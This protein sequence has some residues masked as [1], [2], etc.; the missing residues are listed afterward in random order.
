MLKHIRYGLIILCLIFPLLAQ[1]K[2]CTNDCDVRFTV[3]P[4]FTSACPSTDLSQTGIY[5]IKND[6]AGP[7]E[8]TDNIITN[9]DDTSPTG[10]SVTIVP[11]PNNDC[12][13]SSGFT[14]AAGASCN[15]SVDFQ[16]PAPGMWIF[17]R[18]LQITIPA[19]STEI[20]SPAI[21]LSCIPTIL[22]SSTVT[23]TGN[24]FVNGDVAVSPGTAITG[25]SPGIVTN[26]SL[27]PTDSI[28]QLA[29]EYAITYY[30]NAIAQTCTTTYSTPQDLGGMTLM[31]GVYCFSSSAGLTGNLT[32]D[33]Q[34]NPNSTFIFKIGSTLIAEAG[35]K[36][37]LENSAVNSN[38]TW[39]VGS[40]ATLKTG[41]AFQGIIDAI[42]SITFVTRASLAGR[43]W[44]QGAAITLDTNMVNWTQDGAVALYANAIN[45]N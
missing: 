25:F 28:A 7:L 36:V 40:S 15:I 3:T 30:N 9:S 43:A 33:G 17:D 44:A 10:G 5:T 4:N 23:N 31:P 34:G 1:A 45:Q 12:G 6:T 21:T 13:L 16:S 14:L 26:G 19:T 35:S 37:I 22:G 32:L 38:V 27:R 42:D 2:I 24:T 20:N 18:I 8:L 29:H 11:A 41:T 39:A